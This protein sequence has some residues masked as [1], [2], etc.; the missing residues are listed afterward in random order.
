MTMMG[1]K[2]VEYVIFDMDG[3]LIDT[4]AVYTKVTNDILAPYGATLTWDIKAG[5]MGK[6]QPDSAA[7]LLS[8]F[9]EIPLTIDSYL[10]KL[11]AAQDLLWPTVRPLPGVQKLLTHLAKH[12][13][14]IA[15]ATSSQRRNF[16]RKTGHL[17]DVFGCFDDSETGEE[18]VICADD[19][20]GMT[21]GKPEPYIFL[22]AASEK[23]KRAVGLTEGEDVTEEQKLERGLGLVFEDAILGVEAG[24]RAGMS[25]VWVPDSNLLNV[26]T[27]TTHI[28]D[29]TLKSIEEFKPEEWGLPPYPE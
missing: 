18:R 4:E 11:A 8:H 27:T 20:K 7:H 15:V 13:V 2:K 17:Q 24:K 22:Y 26:E 21:R 1:R 28:P 23:L 3:L 6:I 14:P 12:N 29:Q 9:P 19:V 10:A 16:E 5:L 25:V